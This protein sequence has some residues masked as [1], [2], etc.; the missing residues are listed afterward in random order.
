MAGKGLIGEALAELTEKVFDE[1]FARKDQDLAQ[2]QALTASLFQNQM[3]LENKYRAELINAGVSLPT[4]HQSSGYMDIVNNAG[5]QPL[6]DTLN[7]LYVQ[8]STNLNALTN[9][10]ASY[11]KGAK[12][13]EEYSAGVDIDG[14]R[15]IDVGAYTSGEEGIEPFRYS[16][17]EQTKIFEAVLGEH[18]WTGD[19]STEQIMD[20]VNQYSTALYGTQPKNTNEEVIG[21][22]KTE[23]P[24]SR[25]FIKVEDGQLTEVQE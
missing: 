3:D 20:M 6:L 23:I 5:N 14:D 17:A 9:I 11:T 1:Y 8:S 22:S 25:K 7:E 13:A 2:T 19:R 24:L 15:I 21:E 10:K 16:P 12:M 4:E 18:G